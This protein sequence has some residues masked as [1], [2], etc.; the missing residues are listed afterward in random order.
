MTCTCTTGHSRTLAWSSDEFI[1]PGG[2]R[3]EFASVQP[4]PT[5][6]N[7]SGS[8]AFA[9]LTNS[10]NMNGVVVLMSDFTF[11]V[12][13]NVTIIILTCMN[14]GRHSSSSIIVPMSS[15]CFE[16]HLYL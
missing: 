7:I 14:V 6:Q 13:E 10:S 12:S 5:R 9:V 2:A 15:K 8:N 1:G 11:I 3:L 16:I 4:V